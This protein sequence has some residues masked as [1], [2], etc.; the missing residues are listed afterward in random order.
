MNET[1]FYKIKNLSIEERKELLR[2][3]KE[4]SYIWWVDILDFTKSFL[5]EKI[6]L[7]F[8]EIMSKYTNACHFSIIHR[9]SENKLEIAFRTMNTGPDYFLW[10]ECKPDKIE[11]FVSKYKLERWGP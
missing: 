4:L 8:E 6:D 10:I 1:I 3:A 11:H 5:R 7:S 9:I 2:E